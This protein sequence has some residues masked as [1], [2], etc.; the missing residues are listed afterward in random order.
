MTN[1]TAEMERVTN[2]FKKIELQN[3]AMM[4]RRG[5]NVDNYETI[6]ELRDS[7]ERFVASLS[8][9]QQAQGSSKLLA[10]MIIGYLQSP[11]ENLLKSITDRMR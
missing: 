11:E 5:R 2:F 3:V 4:E 7:F 10:N 1:L 8:L 9:E 6:C